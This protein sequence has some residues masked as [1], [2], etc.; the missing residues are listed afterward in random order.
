MRVA[1]DRLKERP[2]AWDGVTG[3][4]M[5]SGVDIVTL[6]WYISA[7]G[8]NGFDGGVAAGNCKPRGA[9]LVK[10]AHH[11]KCHS[12]GLRGSPAGCLIG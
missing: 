6:L 1:W 10:S 12:H 5:R 7:T 4:A 3:M 2:R 9:D 8:M 11:N